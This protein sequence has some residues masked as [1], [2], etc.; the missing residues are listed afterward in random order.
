MDEVL[1]PDPNDGDSLI[2]AV[3]ATAMARCDDEPKS[4][5]CTLGKTR[6]TVFFA[7]LASCCG[8]LDSPPTR[9]CSDEERLQTMKVC[10]LV[11][12]V[13][14]QVL[15]L[16][17]IHLLEMTRCQIRAFM[18]SNRD[19]SQHFTAAVRWDTVYHLLWRFNGKLAKL[20][21]SNA[22]AAVAP[23]DGPTR[24]CITAVTNALATDHALLVH[25]FDAYRCYRS[26]ATQMQM[27]YWH[28]DDKKIMDDAEMCADLA[29]VT[30]VESIL[31]STYIELNKSLDDGSDMVREK[32]TM[33]MDM[34]TKLL[35]S[36]GVL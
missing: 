28:N 19:K 24:A 15:I 29:F 32:V 23:V 10:H 5:P 36:N 13:M 26:N 27:E 22:S 4:V 2:L 31:C 3:I 14:H 25:Y 16:C 35:Q 12:N 7:T 30:G 8:L 6:W 18:D 20:Q 11:H 21:T 9:P 33:S 17:L 34:V 1:P